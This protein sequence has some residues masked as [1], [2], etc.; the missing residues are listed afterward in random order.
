VVRGMYTAAAGMLVAQANVDTIANN[1]AN[2][3]TNGFKRALVQVQSQP[4]KDVYRYQTDPG[5]TPGNRLNGVATAAL[6]GQMG[7]GSQIYDT[8][9][10]MEQGAVAATGSELDVALAGPGFFQ[11]RGADGTQAYTRDGHFVRTNTGDL[12]TANGDSVV[13]AAT[14]NPI[15]LPDGTKI[16]IARDGTVSADGVPIDRIAMSEFSNLTALRPQGSNR[17]VDTG[18]AQPVAATQTTALQGSLEKSNANVVTSMVD[19][20]TNERW[21]DANQKVVTTEDEATG[22]A[23]QTVGRTTAS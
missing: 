5:H 11:I 7:S 16:G 9:N 13:S 12:Q 23:I 17:Y 14:G 21:F 2:V 4:M 18:A 15:N 10:V 20:I 19:L 6:I 3:D 8:P 22:V 1:L